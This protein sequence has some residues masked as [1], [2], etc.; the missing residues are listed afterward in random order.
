MCMIFLFIICFLNVLERFLFRVKN[1]ASAKSSDSAI[2][3]KPEDAINQNAT[4]Q[5]TKSEKST[6]AATRKTSRKLKVSRTAASPKSSITGDLKSAKAMQSHLDITDKM[7]SNPETMTNEDLDVLANGDVSNFEDGVQSCSAR[8]EI[9]DNISSNLELASNDNLDVFSDD[10]NG[11][12]GSVSEPNSIVEVDSP[13]RQVGRKRHVLQ[14]TS[15]EENC[16]SPVKQLNASSSA[17]VSQRVLSIKLKKCDDYFKDIMPPA[18]ASSRSN[19][20][21]LMLYARAHQQQPA[22]GWKWCAPW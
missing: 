12:E 8:T 13:I 22:A 18:T 1:P 16:E 15:S 21:L 10:G 17:N 20:S 6:S 3:C 5:R 2:S 9:N 11:E 4:S 14:Y 19:S 7:L